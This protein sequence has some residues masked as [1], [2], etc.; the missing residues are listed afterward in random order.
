[1]IF[2]ITLIKKRLLFFYFII[3]TIKNDDTKKTKTNT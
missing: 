1:M 3:N 2:E